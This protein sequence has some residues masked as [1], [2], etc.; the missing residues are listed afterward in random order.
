MYRY[1]V[2]ESRRLVSAV[3]EGELT[4]ADLFEYLTDMLGSTAYGAGW[5]S[6]LDFTRVE[7]VGLTVAGVERM[8]DLPP[9]METRLHGAR[10]V[11]LAPPG[12]AAFGMARMY[13]MMR[14]NV[15]YQI[16]VLSDRD[17]AMEWLYAR[18]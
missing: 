3:F 10:A 11:I 5:H 2:D 17:E 4:D 14:D 16:A 18:G 12:S 13:E 9:E 15:P 8:R 6:F 1:E 7:A